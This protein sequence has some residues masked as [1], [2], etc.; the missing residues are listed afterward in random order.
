MKSRKSQKLDPARKS[1]SDATVNVQSQEA[2]AQEV[3]QQM[4]DD[5]FDPASKQPTPQAEPDE[6]KKEEAPPAE[7]AQEE[8]KAQEDAGSSSGEEAKV[9]TF[10]PI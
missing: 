3:P 10:T 5:D 2:K 1:Q 9:V 6:E 7:A 8:A 4:K